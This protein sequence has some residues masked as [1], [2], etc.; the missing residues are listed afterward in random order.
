MTTDMVPAPKSHSLRLQ[1]S[2][3]SKE[4]APH[5]VALSQQLAKS[6]LIP[7]NY[8]GKPTD[9]YVAMAMGY[10]LGLPVEQAIQDIAVINGRPC[11]WGDGLLAVIMQHDDFEDIIEEPMMKGDVVTGYTCTIKRKGRTPTVR[12]FTLDLAKKAGLLGKQGPWTTSTERMLQ[13]RARSFAAR[14]SFP[15]ALRGIKSREEVEDYIDAE[16]KEVEAPT[17]RTEMIKNDILTRKGLQNETEPNHMATPNENQFA[18]EETIED[19]QSAEMVNP[20]QEES[21]ASTCPPKLSTEQELL[22]LKL[23]KETALSD[24]RFEA[25]MKYY[26]VE[27]IKDLTPEKAAHFIKQLEKA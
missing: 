21:L 24:E 6:T 25:A 23:L 22:I 13:L 1:D 12:R 16:Y 9:I 2:L 7:K 19:H 11:L 15:D 27:L 5:Y 14:D 18:Q 17:S 26:E 20:G 4:L 3:F 10:Q 8:I